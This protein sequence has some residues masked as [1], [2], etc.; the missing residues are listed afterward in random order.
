MVLLRT[1]PFV[2][3]GFLALACLVPFTEAD[4]H[5]NVLSD[6]RP[7]HPR[8]PHDHLVPTTPDS[9]Q[10][11]LKEE[12]KPGKKSV[13]PKH[14][15]STATNGLVRGVE[16]GKQ[17]LD[18]L[19]FRF[20]GGGGAEVSGNTLSLEDLQLAAISGLSGLAYHLKPGSEEQHERYNFLSRCSGRG[21]RGKI[22]SDMYTDLVLRASSQN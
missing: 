8:H 3:A 1:S 16:V 19:G 15:L 7:G 20:G 2:L 10:N 22:S 4:P 11:E 21:M 17:A 18:V 13:P 14:S 6:A 9:P 5:A 12:E